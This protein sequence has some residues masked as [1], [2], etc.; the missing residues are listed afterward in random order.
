MGDPA[1]AV[2]EERLLKENTVER[3]CRIVAGSTG[4]D[5]QIGS[6]PVHPVILSEVLSIMSEV[7]V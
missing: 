3:I 4:P 2:A 1:G 6:Y 5:A 7:N